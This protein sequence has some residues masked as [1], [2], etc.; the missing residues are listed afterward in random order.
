MTA[1]DRSSP[2][3]ATRAYPSRERSARAAFWSLVDLAGGQGSSFIV[4]LVLARVIGPGQY[5]VFALAWSLLTL[6][7]IVQYYGFA[8]AI[9]TASRSSTVTTAPERFLRS[10]E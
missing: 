2:I 3:E 8:D 6:L 4:F 10:K 5:G 7:A 1:N 9:S